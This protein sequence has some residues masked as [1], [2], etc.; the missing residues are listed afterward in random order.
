MRFG[1]EGKAAGG[2]EAALTGGAEGAG[3]ETADT[4]ILRQ[5]RDSLVKTEK[6]PTVEVQQAGLA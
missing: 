1:E 4:D 5:I 3:R 2:L 6:K